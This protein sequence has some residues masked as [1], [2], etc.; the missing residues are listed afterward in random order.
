[1]LSFQVFIKLLSV[2]LGLFS[3]LAEFLMSAKEIVWLLL[4]STS[5]GGLWGSSAGTWAAEG[6]GGSE[7][8]F[9]RSCQGVWWNGTGEQGREEPGGEEVV[10]SG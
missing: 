10:G 2:F 8:L 3:S 5:M 4:V 6:R 1:M 9:W 7:C